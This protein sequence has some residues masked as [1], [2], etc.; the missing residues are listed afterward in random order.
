M[1]N[2]YPNGDVK[3]VLQ[4]RE[5]LSAEVLEQLRSAA[6]KLGRPLTQAEFLEIVPS[7]RSF[8]AQ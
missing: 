8:V 7:P 2:T 4:C 3:A 1:A 5:A 6:Q